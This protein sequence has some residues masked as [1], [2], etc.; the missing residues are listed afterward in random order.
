M[1]V[2]IFWLYV[3]RFMLNIKPAKP[4]PPLYLVRQTPP[5]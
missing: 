4:R 1:H 3:I 5:E 2:L